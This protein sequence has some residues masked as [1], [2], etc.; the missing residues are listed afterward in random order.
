MAEIS[1]EKCIEFA[2]LT[3]LNLH[4]WRLLTGI[5]SRKD[6]S[7]MYK[8]EGIFPVQYTDEALSK[9]T[10]AEQF[11]I[12][13]FCAT[14][15]L[16]F[17]CLPSSLLHFIDNLVLGDFSV[18]EDFRMAVEQSM[19]GAGSCGT[20]SLVDWYN[21]TLSASMWFGL[22]SVAPREAAMLLCQFNPNDE[23]YEPLKVFNTETGPGD[24]RRLLRVFEDI[25]NADSKPR[26]LMQWLGV[27][28]DKGLKYHSWVDEYLAAIETVKSAQSEKS[29]SG[30][31]DA[32]IGWVAQVREIALEYI[33]R[34]KAND[35]FP[36]LSDVCAHVA[37]VSR[38]KKIYGSQGKPLS[39]SY[40]QRNAIQGEWWK[41]NRP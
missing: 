10:A 25:A 1:K 22:Q 32:G 41:K 39:Q 27:A 3:E 36:S 21:N 13:E 34:H 37:S 14:E 12:G 30:L 16:L 5:T 8:R 15:P 40:I 35:L 4:H 38:G 33:A 11:E 24:Y 2:Q 29:P 26:A 7:F 31:P 20:D 28:K 23:Q 19:R 18:P 17:P 9:L 6:D